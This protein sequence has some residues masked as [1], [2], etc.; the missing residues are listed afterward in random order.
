MS[1]FLPPRWI[2]VAL[3]ALVVA[4]SLTGLGL[5]VASFWRPFDGSLALGSD[6]RGH[7]FSHRGRIT[8]CIEEGGGQS[9]SGMGFLRDLTAGIRSIHRAKVREAEMR[10][11]MEKLRQEV[12]KQSQ[13]SS[14]RDYRD[15]DFI[16][17]ALS[18]RARDQLM[19]NAY[20]LAIA[21]TAILPKLPKGHG[22]AGLVFKYDSDS[23][24]RLVVSLPT[25]FLTVFLLIAPGLLTFRI[26]R[27]RRR[28]SILGCKRCAYNLTGL[29]SSVCPECGTLIPDEQKRAIVM[30]AATPRR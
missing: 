18:K 16:A 20:Q 19:A 6:Y 12:E 14:S 13:G 24:E 22:Y 23:E 17:S 21:E 25:W 1:P 5:L 26:V 3:L 11:Q 7:F 27:G 2:R 9:L 10:V 30:E 15:L 28:Y 8:I 29:T 4:V